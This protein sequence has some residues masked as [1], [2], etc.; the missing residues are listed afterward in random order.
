MKKMLHAPPIAV[1]FD[2]DRDREADR[3]RGSR[4]C[5]RA[6]ERIVEAER[7]TRRAMRHA[8]TRKPGVQ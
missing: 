5:A 8:K 4:A 2:D 7:P 1:A 6:A 3:G